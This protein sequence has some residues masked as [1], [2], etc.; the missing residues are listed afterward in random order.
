MQALDQINAR[1]QLALA[2]LATARGLDPGALAAAAGLEPAL[3]ARAVR[4][5]GAPEQAAQALLSQVLGLEY[6]ELLALGRRLENGLDEAGG[7]P[8][9]HSGDLA[10]YL[11]RMLRVATSFRVADNAEDLYQRI[12]QALCLHFPFRRAMLFLRGEGGMDLRSLTWE[13][14]DA[15]GLADALRREPPRLD[16]LS[17]EYESFALGRSLPLEV[18]LSDFFQAPA[19]A[20]L[21]EGTE[22]ALAPLFTD[23][24]FIGVV[25]ADFAGQEG[26]RLSDGDLASLETFATLSG[27]LLYNVWLYAELEDKNRE[28]ELKVREL[29]VVGEMT[30]ILNRALSPEDMARQ[31]LALLARTMGADE[32]F[33]FL[34]DQEARELKLFAGHDL[35]R[36]RQE[37]W[38]RLAG[39]TPEV[40]AAAGRESKAGVSGGLLPG[41]EGPAILRA[42]KS[43]DKDIGA[44]GLAR[45]AGRKPFSRMD[46]QALATADEQVTVALTSMRLRRMATTDLLTGLYTRTHFREALD[47][48]LKVGRYLGHPLSLVLLDA[49]FFKRVNDEHGHLAGDA[50]LAALGRTLRSGT[51]HTDVAARIGGEEFALLLPRC[52]EN[53]ARA[54]ADKIRAAVEKG[55]VNHQGREI[56]L[57]MSLGVA[58][59]E[60]GAV[61]APDEL[62]NRA[63]QALYRAKRQGR[64]RVC[65]YDPAQDTAGWGSVAETPA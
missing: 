3:V 33:L 65:L 9:G 40:M 25:E 54:V 15:A 56:R 14:G 52:D 22:V 44:W 23:R 28:L 47:Q 53:Q 27:S 57:T 6:D 29:T 21:G 31:M 8:E 46:E 50:V 7:G 43:G 26:R 35:S 4:Q 42:L 64:N 2:H 58:S 20:I 18:G 24:E 16:P 37:S 48:E 34:Y 55:V 38:E 45:R 12:T 11:S 62:L 60:P 19:R 51:R 61:L 59:Q 41:L 10:A 17:V 36:G 30:R 5:Q 1:F 39:V 49:D 63:D 13:D 32:G